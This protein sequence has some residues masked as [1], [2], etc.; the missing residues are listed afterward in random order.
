MVPEI[1]AISRL[2]NLKVPAKNGGAVPL[3]A[4][5]DI[6]LD[7]GPGAIERYDRVIR[8]AVEAKSSADLKN[9]RKY[10][11]EYHFLLECRDGKIASVKEYLDTQHAKEILV[12]P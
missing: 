12:D 1:H 8:V 2:E 5:A 9:G 3:A 10:R 4:V 7:Q 6:E 11:N